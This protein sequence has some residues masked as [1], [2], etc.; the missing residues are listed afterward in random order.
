MAEKKEAPLEG[1]N[2]KQ[3]QAIQ[4]TLGVQQTLEQK[5]FLNKGVGVEAGLYTACCTHKILDDLL[6][7][8]LKVDN[9]QWIVFFL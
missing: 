5:A 7:I 6:T 3:K 1:A 4:E 2:I 8:F 9:P